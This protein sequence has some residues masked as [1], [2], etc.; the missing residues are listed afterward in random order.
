[1]YLKPFGRQ[2]ARDQVQATPSERP[3]TTSRLQTTIDQ[4][5]EL[6]QFEFNGQAFRKRASEIKDIRKYLIIASILVAIFIV[7]VL[8]VFVVLINEKLSG[9][10]VT[11]PSGAVAAGFNN[12]LGT[13]TVTAATMATT[14]TMATAEKTTTSPTTSK[15]KDI[16][17]VKLKLFS[18]IVNNCLA[19]YHIA[20]SPCSAHQ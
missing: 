18:L 3:Q 7:V 12:A 20:A 15:N 10:Q 17:K 2:V 19:C 14:T 8:F 9:L 5:R 6:I 4:L 11:N 1:L 13:T 16:L